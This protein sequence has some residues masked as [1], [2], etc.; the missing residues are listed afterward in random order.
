MRYSHSFALLLTLLLF[1]G[2]SSKEV[3]TPEKPETGIEISGYIDEKIV[4][5][6]PEGALL[7][8]GALLDASGVV[9]VV[10]PEGYRYIGKS[11]GWAISGKVNGE[12]LLQSVS[13]D[14]N[15]SFEL[16]KTVAAATVKGD[17][18]AVLFASNDMALYSLSE[19]SLLFK[20]RANTPVAVDSRIYNPYFL[21]ELVLFLTLDGK[22]VIVNSKT[23]QMLRSMMV[24]SDDMVNNI[25]YF[26]VIED[27][28]MAATSGQIYTFAGNEI[29]ESYDL[30]D[31]VYDKDGV[32]IATK[33]GEVIALS[34][35][36]EVKAKKKFPFAHFLAMIATD[37]KLYLLEKAGYFIIID[38]SFDTVKVHRVEM[39]DGFVYASGKRFYFAV[40]AH[41]DEFGLTDSHKY[42]DK[43]AY[44]DIE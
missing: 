30:R 25:I 21:N 1:A 42:T 43:T 19:K 36:L 35:T 6:T 12:L 5:T 37:D 11:D 38:K 28:V 4:D 40:A 24:G 41:D 32:W 33:Q 22:V 10:I 8:S 39:E 29:R 15:E 44:I 23:K 16:K 27:R 3:Y 20:E 26:N 13:E 34:P 9:P 14:R 18:L 31:I 7:E 2:C 17:T